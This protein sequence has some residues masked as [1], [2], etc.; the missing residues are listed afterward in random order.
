MRIAKLY[1]PHG[2]PHDS[3]G[4]NFAKYMVRTLAFDPIDTRAEWLNRYARWLNDEQRSKLMSY[5]PYWYGKWALGEKLELHDIDR[6]ELDIRTIEA[7]DVTPEQRKAANLKKDSSRQAKQRR[8][9]GVRTR[10]DYLAQCKSR[11]KPWLTEGF[12][13]R[14]TW[15]RHKALDPCRNSN[16]PPYCLN[17]NTDVS[18]DTPPSKAPPSDAV[19]GK[20]LPG[21]SKVPTPSHPWMPR[22][23]AGLAVPGEQVPRALSNHDRRA[24]AA[25]VEADVSKPSPAISTTPGASPMSYLVPMKEAA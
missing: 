5:G 6:M 20:R 15:E 8:A 4:Y 12:K 11:T 17:T 21:S 7:F 2:L 24:R 18:C 9:A 10:E 1:Y 13:C 19:A 23:V 25:A 22:L 16:P 14:R 3:V